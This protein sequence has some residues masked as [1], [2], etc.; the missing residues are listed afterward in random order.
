MKNKIL[1][2]VF[3]FLFLF[4]TLTGASAKTTNKERNDIIEAGMNAYDKKDYKKAIYHLK[5]YEKILE[6]SDEKLDTPDEKVDPFLTFFSIGYS[7]HSIGEEDEALIYFNKTK[8]L[9]NE[10]NDSEKRV[11]LISTAIYM[12]RKIGRYEEVIASFNLFSEELRNAT[13]SEEVIVIFTD[14]AMCYVYLNDY[15][16]SLSISN[17]VI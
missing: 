9:A 13:P 2:P 8:N 3:A 15:N 10:F 5:K 1:I 4:A 12:L 17:E 11:E 14:V 6:A 16:N 7:L